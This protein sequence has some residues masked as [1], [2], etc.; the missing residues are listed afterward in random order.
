MLLKEYIR[1][2]VFDMD[3]GMIIL[4]FAIC[5]VPL[6]VI[7]SILPYI[8][9]KTL[10]FGV[11]I[12][13]AVYDDER[14]KKLRK[15]FSIK[16]ITAGLAIAALSVI[17]FFLMEAANAISV[18]TALVLVYVLLIF[19]VYL[20]GNKAVKKIKEEEGWD[21]DAGQRVVADTKFSSSKHAVSA[22]WFLLYA[23]IIIGTLLLGI[24]MY[25]QIPDK[26]VMQM[27]TAGNP[28]RL[29]DK[30]F[31]LILF[32]PATQAAIAILMGFVYWMMGRT[33][34]VIDPDQPEV[35]SAQNAKFRYGWSAF[36]VFMGIALLLVFSVTQM[37]FV[38]WIPESLVLWIPM[39]ITGAMIIAAIVLSIKMGQSGNRIRIGKTADGKKINRDDDRY[40]KG[41]MF[42]VNKNDPALFVEKRFG[43]GFTINFGRPAAVLVFLGIIAVIVLITVISNGLAG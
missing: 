1:K 42:Y 4:T 5:Y 24:L 3:A 30:S 32:A 15:G 38:G 37:W 2:G 20:A 39:G 19:P 28:T 9:R 6:I 17:P 43:V 21:I 13:S 8:S 40:W 16:V 41:G 18:M 26:V 36:T 34:P 25:D 27:D 33:P 23:V 12:P 35:S 11:S 31:G 29:A 7:F 10:T 14:L 22:L